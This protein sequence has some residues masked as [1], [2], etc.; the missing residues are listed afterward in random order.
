MGVRQS[1]FNPTQPV[2]FRF[3]A[4]L[5]TGETLQAR[6]TT[7]ESLATVV[8]QHEMVPTGIPFLYEIAGFTLRFNDCCEVEGREVIVSVELIDANGF[9]GR[10]ERR[11]RSGLCLLAD[12]SKVCER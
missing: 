9:S 5:S 1:R 6:L 4:R 10:D 11:V 8:W 2:H 12:G 3:Q 7:G